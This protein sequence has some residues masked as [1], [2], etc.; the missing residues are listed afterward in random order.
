MDRGLISFFEISSCGFYRRKNM[1]PELICG[2]LNES[3]TSVTEWLQDRDFTQT[4][5]W[6]VSASPNRTKIYCKI[7]EKDEATGD[8]MFVLWNRFGDDSGKVAGISADAKFGD[9]EGDSVNI[10]TKDKGKPVV[11]GQPMYYWFIPEHN[12][13]ASINFP[14]STAATEDVCLYI[15]RCIDLRVHHPNKTTNETVSFNPQSNKQITTKTVNYLS[16]DGQYSLKYKFECHK[17]ELSFERYNLSKLANSISHLVIRDTISTE[18]DH[19]KDPTFRLYDIIRGVRTKKVFTKQ[20][21]IV[22]KA[23]FTVDELSEIARVHKEE[24]CQADSWNNI[25]FR[26]ES[27]D[28]THWLNDYARKEQIFVEPLKDG[29]TYH[30]AKKLMTQVQRIREDILVFVAAPKQQ[31]A[32]AVGE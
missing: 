1:Q 11:L 19:S 23:D 18:Q 10:A 30:T 21:E 9:E 6:D 29:N 8:F 17:K 3:L 25:G 26:E 15:K 12:L 24:Y 28:V 31:E 7:V 2:S 5:P 16:E 13:V 14:H 4:I 27:R 32:K 22:E 20:V